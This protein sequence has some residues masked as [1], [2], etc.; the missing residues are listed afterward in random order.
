M[1]AEAFSFLLECWGVTQLCPVELLRVQWLDLTKKLGIT[2]HSARQ[3]NQRLAE[4]SFF[5]LDGP[6]PYLRLKLQHDL[7]RKKTTKKEQETTMWQPKLLN[8]MIKRWGTDK[9]NGFW[10]MRCTNLM[11]RSH[12]ISLI[13]L[14]NRKR[15]CQNSRDAFKLICDMN[16]LWYLC[17]P[18]PG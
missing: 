15:A 10:S 9:Y 12:L 14:V 7:C 2:F 5:A 4:Q 16:W 17:F 6:N 1:L 11:L 3:G 18:L 13:E 8:S